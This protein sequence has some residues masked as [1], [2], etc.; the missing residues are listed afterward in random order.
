MQSKGEK[1]DAQKISTKNSLLFWGK[2]DIKSRKAQ[3][4]EDVNQQQRVGH[5]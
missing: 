3:S 4:F 5:M 2:T 1:E